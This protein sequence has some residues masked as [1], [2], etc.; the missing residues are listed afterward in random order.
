MVAGSS[1][2]A[3]DERPVDR[4]SVAQFVAMVDHDLTGPAVI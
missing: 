3:A 2:V 4:G 1:R